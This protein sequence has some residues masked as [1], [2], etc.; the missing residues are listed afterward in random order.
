MGSNPRFWIAVGQLFRVYALLYGAFF[1]LGAVD[2]IA[3]VAM[4][5][6]STATVL[7]LAI[8]GVLGFA[9][10]RLMWQAKPHLV[11]GSPLARGLAA[12]LLVL[13]TVTSFGIALLILGAAYWITRTPVPPGPP[14]PPYFQP[15]A[16]IG[17]SG[18]MAWDSPERSSIV[19]TLPSGVA[20]Q[21]RGRFGS[22]AEVMV[23]SGH[24]GWVDV[25]TL[26][27]LIPVPQPT[28]APTA[29]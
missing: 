15:D 29:G 1:V 16:L 22:F 25:R 11:S 23:A 9:V 27:A 8:G 12:F 10:L 20:V 13:G 4:G 18:A 7:Q 19:A 14:V 3:R 5:R 17:P 26:A 28:T 21:V 6:G 24:S 2:L